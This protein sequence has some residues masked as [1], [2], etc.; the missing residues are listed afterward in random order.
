MRYILSILLFYSSTNSWASLQDHFD[1][2]GKKC[3]QATTLLIKK[4]ALELGAKADCS[5]TFTAQLISKCSGLNCEE[6]LQS[7]KKNA[8]GRS[9]AVVGE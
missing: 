2:V 7:Y 5:Q 3:D 6:L 4:S 9:G 8:Q 1:F